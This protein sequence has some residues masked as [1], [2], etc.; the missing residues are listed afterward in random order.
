VFDRF[1]FA[2]PA[3]VEQTQDADMDRY[4]LKNS[5]TQSGDLL[6]I[7]RQA[8]AQ[9]A[10]AALWQQSSIDTLKQSYPQ[11]QI[12]DDQTPTLSCAGDTIDR[13]TIQ[14]SFGYDDK[15]PLYFAQDF[16]IYEGKAYVLLYSSTR[17]SSIKKIINHRKTLQCSTS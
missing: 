11:I 3:I 1:S 15:E 9:D 10:D 14:G 7:Y 8:I 5:A 13:R 2:S 16:F 17:E 12:T 6:T 4:V